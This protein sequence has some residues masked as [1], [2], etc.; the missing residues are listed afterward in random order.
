MPIL[1]RDFEIVVRWSE[2]EWDGV[3]WSNSV[4]GQLA[5]INSL[6]LLCEMLPLFENSLDTS[7]YCCHPAK[8]PLIYHPNIVISSVLISWLYRFYK[9]DTESNLMVGESFGPSFLLV[10][11]AMGF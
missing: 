1:Q 3:R 8:D 5:V 7:K 4:K 11:M 9:F 6:F 2:M 10:K